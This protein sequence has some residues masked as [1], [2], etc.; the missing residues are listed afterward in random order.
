VLITGCSSEDG[1]GAAA[2]RA[3][4]ERGDTVHAAVHNAQ[5]APVA[6]AARTWSLE[7]RDHAQ[8]A[9]VV[10]GVIDAEGR[11]DVLINNAGYGLIGG[12][13]AV[14]TDQVR[15]HLDVN[16]VGTLALIQAA[17]PALR[18]QGSG[19]VINVSSIFAAGRCPPGIGLY[20]ASK[21]ALDTACQ[22]LAVEAA[23]SGVRV[24]S[25]QP[26]PVATELSRVWGDRTPPGGDP[27]PDLPDELYRWV[28]SEG[29]QM[30]SSAE[31]AKAL[32]ELV[33]DPNPP[34]AMQTGGASHQYVAA[35]LRD[36]SGRE[37]LDRML[38]AFSAA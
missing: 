23:P 30:Q 10:R 9:G 28:T 14:S 37:A 36:P 32:V 4:A 19:H 3:L 26:G 18:R 29:P 33:H 22:A 27:R 34:P 35:E 12:V 2:V 5:A 38:N 24:T 15:E 7:L 20:V 11:I 6:G 8:A 21:A 25:F 16:V 13:E 31:V 17:L 1:I